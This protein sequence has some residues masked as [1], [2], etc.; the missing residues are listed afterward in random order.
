LGSPRRSTGE[1]HAWPFVALR[2]FASL[3]VVARRV[4]LGEA[5][6]HRYFG[7]PELTLGMAGTLGVRIPLRAPGNSLLIGVSSI[8]LRD[9][10]GRRRGFSAG[11][12]GV[13]LAL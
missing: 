7:K 10:D 13:E 5:D 2:S 9:R 6:D 8:D 12:L 3:P 4:Y 1:P 11:S